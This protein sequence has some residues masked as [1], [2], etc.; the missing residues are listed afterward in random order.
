MLTLI[1]S[2]QMILNRWLQTSLLE[3]GNLLKHAL[4]VRPAS[5]GIPPPAHGNSVPPPARGNSIPPP[6]NH[7]VSQCQKQNQLERT[8]SSGHQAKRQCKSKSCEREADVP[9]PAVTTPLEPIP[10][11]DYEVYDDNYATTDFPSGNLQDAMQILTAIG[12]GNSDVTA[13]NVAEGGEEFDLDNIASSDDDSSSE[14]SGLDLMQY[15]PRAVKSMNKY[16]NPS[17]ERPWGAPALNM[18]H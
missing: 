1:L 6:N 17:R 7:Q 2:Q 14:D 13:R 10:E 4:D 9:P 18:I 12:G 15:H 16:P 11:F 5:G 3:A 8:L